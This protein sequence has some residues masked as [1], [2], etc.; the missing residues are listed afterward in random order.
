MNI[1]QR[2]LWQVVEVAQA[3]LEVLSTRSILHR[4]ANLLERRSPVIELPQ[5]VDTRLLQRTEQTSLPGCFVVLAFP[6]VLAVPDGLGLEQVSRPPQN[7]QVCDRE[8]VDRPLHAPES[9]HARVVDSAAGLASEA[10]RTWRHHC[11]DGL[12]SK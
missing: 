5:D 3:M 9:G 8:A 11:G 7:Q 4:K 1:C 10:A 6:V 12:H 2:G